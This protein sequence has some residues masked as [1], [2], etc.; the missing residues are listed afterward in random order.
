MT[1]NTPAPG[2]DFSGFHLSKTDTQQIL[3]QAEIERARHM[4]ELLA[5]FGNRI[6]AAFRSAG[7]LFSLTQRMN[8]AARL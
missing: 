5:P 2:V 6:G 8:Q 1:I 4:R 3:R 7:D